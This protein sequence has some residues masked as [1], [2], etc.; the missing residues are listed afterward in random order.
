MNKVLSYKDFLSQYKENKDIES[1]P[2]LICKTSKWNLSDL[3][4]DVLD[5]YHKLLELNPNHT[6]VYFDDDDCLDF[7]ETFYPEYIKHYNKVIPT[8]YKADLFRYLFLHKHG[9][10]YGDMT[11]EIFVSYDSI[12]DNFKRV[13]CRD[14][15]TN[16]LGL[17]NALMCTMPSDPLID[18][19]LDIC[20]KNIEDENYTKSPLGITGPI[21]L[22]KAF[23]EL[24]KLD[25]ILLGENNDS[26]ILDFCKQEN[27]EVIVDTRT[28]EI[29]G[30]PKSKN[31]SKLLYKHKTMGLSPFSTHYHDMWWRKTVFRINIELENEIIKTEPDKKG[32]IIIGIYNT[33]FKNVDANHKGK[34]I[35]VWNNSSTSIVNKDF[36][37]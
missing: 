18:R 25:C 33:S 27:E 9:G 12:C 4:G 35:V 36:Y 26:L 29:I 2:K 11:Q 19:V 23:I 10:C 3:P 24:Y 7:I 6:F 21:A 31:H 17:Y 16:E 1:I 22:G 37:F 34:K 5:I 14:T 13:I 32:L 30:T 28:K 15:V 8:A 20:K